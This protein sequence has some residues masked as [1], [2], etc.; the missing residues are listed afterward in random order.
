VLRNSQT[1]NPSIMN[2]TLPPHDNPNN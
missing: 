1:H 2:S